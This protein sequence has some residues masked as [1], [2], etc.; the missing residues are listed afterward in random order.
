MNTENDNQNQNWPTLKTLPIP[1]KALVSTVILTMML[2]MTGAMGQII[3]HD[4]IPTFYSSSQREHQGSKSVQEMQQ[5]ESDTIDA[6]RGDLFAEEPAEPESVNPTLLDSEQFIWI[7]KWTHIHLFGMNMIFIFMGGITLFLDLSSRSRTW[8]IVLP[9]VGV[10]ID[11]ATMWLK[12]Y[13]SPTFFWLH[14]PGGGL[15]GCMFAFVSLRAF[16][17][18]WWVRKDRAVT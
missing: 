9:F 16:W 10:V 8:L 2:A 5:N 12:T 6:G 17:E 13:I 1:A 7:L 18:M 11:I 4:I 14:L 15:F 3:V